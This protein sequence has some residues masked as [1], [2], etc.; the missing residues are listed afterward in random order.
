M[1]RHGKVKVESF[2]K[3]KQQR[4]PSLRRP[5]RTLTPWQNE[6]GRRQKAPTVSEKDINRRSHLLVQRRAAQ[7]TE[8]VSIIQ[9]KLMNEV[10]TILF[11][12]QREAART[13]AKG[14]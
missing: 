7:P 10:P 3:G 2:P 13:F 12:D 5:D 14:E 9:R 6:K 8:H 11:P 1:S 4:G